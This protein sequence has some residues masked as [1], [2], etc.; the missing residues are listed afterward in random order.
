[1][2]KTKTL[3][4]SLL[5]LFVALSASAQETDKG[6]SPKSVQRLNRAP[7]NKD[8]LK[9]KLPRPVE[10][11][12]PNGLSVLVLEQ[13]KL[14]TV[15]FVLW[16]KSGALHDPKDTPGLSE[17]TAAMM[18]EGTAKRTS[19]QIAAETDQLGATLNTSA[20]YGSGLTTVAISGLVE[21]ADKML[22]LMSDVAL[23][24][25]FPQAELDKYKPRKLAQLEEQRSDPNFLAEE[26]FHQVLYRDFPAA[27][28]S[29]TVASV[30]AMTVEQLKKNHAARFVPGNAILG[31]VGDVTQQ[32]ALELVKKYFGGWK[33]GPAPSNALPALPAPL[34]RK[35]Y[36]IDRPGS[37]Q[38]NLV[39]GGFGLKRTDPDYIPMVVMN[40]ILGGG[41]AS[42]LFLNLREEKGYT[43][44]S[45]S[46]F[47]ADIY[48]GPVTAT[49][50]QRNAVTQGAMDELTKE[51]ARMGSEAVPA[52]ELDETKRSLVA[53]FALSLESPTNLLN[54]WMTVKYY[55]LPVDYWDTYTEKLAA[56]SAAE[57]Q[58]VG[59]K[60]LDAKQLQI[61][62]VGDSKQPGTEEKENA[63]TIKD[64]VSGFGPLEMFDA[65]GKPLK[66]AAA[67][68]KPTGD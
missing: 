54:R 67:A 53:V 36:L 58:R 20:G 5:L 27:V 46:G 23:N 31:V 3:F 39:V 34:P 15:A 16:V 14:P 13:H 59:K 63:K 17:T 1:M 32:Q 21:N 4:A 6:A 24:P 43:Y 26:K 12:L 64:V 42:R 9:V 66:A 29:P 8:V 47:D 11:K 61:V 2:H 22:D 30:N 7:V 49:S 50:E 65:D 40:E 52:D 51:L 28:I 38:T 33:A 60:Y 57:V 18:R 48:P 45:Y 25:S 44:G 35:T 19:V 68:E 37:V 62:V 10:T 56:V 41:A 55:G